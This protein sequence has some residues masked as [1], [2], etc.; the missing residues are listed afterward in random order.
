[1][2]D[3]D[4]IRA[5]IKEI[6]RR[7]TARGAVWATLV[8]GLLMAFDVVEGYGGLAGNA[9]GGVVVWLLIF[10]SIATYRKSRLLKE[11]QQIATI[12]AARGE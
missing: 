11:S 7:D 3:E 1:M 9:I 2:N 10:G 5:E 12:R 6:E 8:V 4:A